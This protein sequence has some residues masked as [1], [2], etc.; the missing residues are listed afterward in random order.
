M[1]TT[2]SPIRHAV[3]KPERED[4]KALRRLPALLPLGRRSVVASLLAGFLALASL[5]LAGCDPQSAAAES[6][7]GIHVESIRLSAAGYMV[8]LRYRVT[9]PA[10]AA[11]LTK[12]GIVSYLVDRQTGHRFQTPIAPKT[13]ALR[14][15]TTNPRTDRVYFAFFANPGRQLQR[16]SQVEVVMGGFHSAPLAVQ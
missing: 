16:G 2:G 9:D 13:G 14:A 7:F 1:K 6:R 8:D 11:N 12:R 15:S 4:G 5:A 3:P 10:K